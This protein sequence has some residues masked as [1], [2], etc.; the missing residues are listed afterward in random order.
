MLVKKWYIDLEWYNIEDNKIYGDMGF[1][2]C[3]MPN[4]RCESLEQAIDNVI[5]GLMYE[6]E[7]FDDNN[8]PIYIVVE[9]TFD[10][11][12]FYVNEKGYVQENYEI[13][14][15]AMINY[16]NVCGYAFDFGF[17]EKINKIWRK[18]EN[19][20]IKPYNGIDIDINV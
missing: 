13:N 10:T 14:S 12:K 17:L 6:I 1:S 16:N 3:E 19:F 11:D 15:D 9:Y 2:F 5:Q 20:D 4:T 8:I 18:N 7:E